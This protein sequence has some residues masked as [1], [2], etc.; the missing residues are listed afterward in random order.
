MRVSRC[1][2]PCA[3]LQNLSQDPEWSQLLLKEGAVKQLEEIATE[4][5]N[6]L[7]QRYAA[8]T[9]KNLMAALHRA[10]FDASAAIVGDAARE[11]VRERATHAALARIQERVAAR[12]IQG[13]FL[14]SAWLR[15]HRLEAQER[16]RQREGAEA[17]SLEHHAR[18]GGGGGRR[19]KAGGAGAAA[20]QSFFSDA[21]LNAAG[22]SGTSRT[23]SP[24]PNSSS[25]SAATGGTSSVSSS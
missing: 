18:K 14:Q 22:V 19:G 10:G 9:L 20:E 5:S 13:A 17:A 12:T 4:P 23:A 15:R 16:Q 8:G 2:G 21:E 6:A 25:Q 7:A 11:A 3:A 1:V 24:S